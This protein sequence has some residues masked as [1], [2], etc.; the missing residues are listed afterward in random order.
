[1]TAKAVTEPGGTP[2]ASISSSGLPKLKRPARSVRA[3]ALRSTRV[4]ALGDDEKQLAALVL[5]EQVLGVRPGKL[6]LELAAFGHR[7]QRLVLDRRA[8]QCRARRGG[9]TG[10]G[11]LRALV[12]AMV[13]V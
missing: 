7:E 10:L 11:G 9:E 2:S 5:E 1:M 4:D 6:A 8:S 3:S 13:D 12:R